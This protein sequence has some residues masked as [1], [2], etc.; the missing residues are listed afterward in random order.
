MEKDD[1]INPQDISSIPPLELEEFECKIPQHYLDKCKNDDMKFVMEKVSE[2][3][4]AIKWLCNAMIDTNRQVRHTNGRLKMAETDIRKLST[5]QKIANGKSKTLMTTGTTVIA[6]LA[7][8]V[9][10]FSVTSK[11]TTTSEQK[12]ALAPAPIVKQFPA[13]QTTSKE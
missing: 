7:L 9:S 11:S 8:L 5:W 2:S 12:T 10:V 1:Y 4:E 13:K 6:I 3:S